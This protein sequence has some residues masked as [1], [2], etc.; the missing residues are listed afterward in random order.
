M[1]YGIN[2]KNFD[3][4]DDDRAGSLPDCANAELDDEYRLRGLNALIGRNNTG[5]S[6]FINAMSFLRDTVT[7]NVADASITRGRPGFYH[8]LIDKE[9]PAEFRVFFKVRNHDTKESMYLQYQLKIS[10][11]TFKSP[12]ITGERV[13]RSIIDED[14][15]RRMENIMNFENGKGTVLGKPATINDHHMTALG[16]YGNISEYEEI[17]LIYSEIYRWFFCK[18]SSDEHGTSQNPNY[19]VDGNA[20]GGHKHLNSHGTNLDNVLEYLKNSDP[21]YY[22]RCIN[23]INSMIPAMKKKKNLPDVLTESPDKLFM[24]LLLLRDPEPKSTIFIEAPDKDLY[25]DMVDVLANE[26]REFTIRNRYSQI[27][28]STHNPYIV[29]TMSPKEIWVFTRTFEKPE[30]DVTI[31]CA[32]E[33]PLVRELFNQGVGMGAIWYGGHLD[34]TTGF[35]DN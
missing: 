32:A 22:A 14:G 30:G 20:P 35:E 8:L 7:D 19:F 34:E 13:C 5:K 17:S 25:H 11:G 10:A 26:F 16:I 3:V 15:K 28:F 21:E 2:I 29:E 33:D 24:Y 1:I 4:F 9:Q 31:R 18:F 6:S 23:E 27:V 12:Q